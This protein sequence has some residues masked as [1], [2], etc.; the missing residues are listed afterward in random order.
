METVNVPKELWNEI[1][2]FIENLSDVRDGKDGP[3]PNDAM[4][5]SSKIT[6]AGL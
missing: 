2:E 1:A 4:L 3:R 6:E 5:L